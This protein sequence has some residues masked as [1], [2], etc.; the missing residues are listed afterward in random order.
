VQKGLRT[1]IVLLALSLA[2]LDASAGSRDINA[3]FLDISE[4]PFADGKSVMQALR[5]RCS[6]DDSDPPYSCPFGSGHLGTLYLHRLPPGIDGALARRAVRGDLPAKRALQSSMRAF[7]DRDGTQVD[8]LYV[9]ERS[10]N[11]VTLFAISRVPRTPTGMKSHPVK[12][13]IRLDSLDALLAALAE[14]LPYVP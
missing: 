5:D 13:R 11:Q 9:Y 14:G 12:R 2:P 8:G 10:T 3:V 1:L 6:D 4:P 7:V